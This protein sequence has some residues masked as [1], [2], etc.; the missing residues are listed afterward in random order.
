MSTYLNAK[1]FLQLSVVDFNKRGL[2]DSGMQ[3]VEMGAE[4]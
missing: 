4:L 3:K 2:R 1:Y